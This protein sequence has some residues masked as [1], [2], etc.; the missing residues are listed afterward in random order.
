[1]SLL[2]GRDVRLSVTD[3]D[4]THEVGG[5]RTRS[6]AVSTETVE[7]THALSRGWRALLPCGGTKRADVTGAGVFVS[8]EAAARVRALALS[9]A[10]AE[11]TLAMSGT[12]TLSGPFQVAS[13]R[14]AGDEDGEASFRLA[15][16][17]AGPVAFTEEGAFT[18]EAA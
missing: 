6:F 16:A 17:S 8:G 1:M 11:W 2:R 15:L 5:L 7:A 3:E 13:L 10:H 12:G 4:G 14:Y 9:G 18:G